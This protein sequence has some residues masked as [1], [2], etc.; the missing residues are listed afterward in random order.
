MRDAMPAAEDEIS[1]YTLTHSRNNLMA[2]TFTTRIFQAEGKNATGIVIPAE[3]I[4]ALGKSKKPGV[5]AT[6]N[7]YTYRS[8]VGVYGDTFLL[9]F[10]AEHRE[11]SGLKAGDEV[12]VILEL[13]TEPRTVEVPEDLVA[14]LSEA[15]VKEIFDTVAFSRR[16][17]YVRQVN[18]AKTQETRE[19]RIAKII[20]EL[21]G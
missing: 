13:D 2:V 19:R 15:G 9:P 5:K 1:P 11:A 8:T 21:S 20:G 18:D 3:A 4:A 7:G 17:E 10:S 12:E 6:F 14:A 16:K